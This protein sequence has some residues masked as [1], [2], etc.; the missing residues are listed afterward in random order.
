MFVDSF[1]KEEILDHLAYRPI[2]RALTAGP[3]KTSWLLVR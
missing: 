3:Y 1:S 2:I